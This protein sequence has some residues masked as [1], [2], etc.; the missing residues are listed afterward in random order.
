MKRRYLLLNLSIAI[1]MLLSGCATTGKSV[2]LGSA[3]GAGAG[4]SIG[5]IAD[6][7]PH[8]QNRIRNILVGTAIGGVV[9]AGAGYIGDRIVKDEKDDA[10]K[11]GKADRDEEISRESASVGTDQPRLVPAK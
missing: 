3:V 4:A 11:K 10:Y 6:P 2:A 5:A 7:G 9:G 8:G 1:S